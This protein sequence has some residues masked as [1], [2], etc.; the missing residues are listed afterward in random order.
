M[1][2]CWEPAFFGGPPWEL[3]AAAKRLRFPLEWF[4]RRPEDKDPSGGEKVKLRL[5]C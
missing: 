4:Y 2:S 3:A 1:S 5:G